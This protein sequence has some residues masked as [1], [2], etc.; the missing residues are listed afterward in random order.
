[1][2][3]EIDAAALRAFYEKSACPGVVALIDY[4][5]SPEGANTRCIGS[6]TIDFDGILGDDARFPTDAEKA[7][8]VFFLTKSLHIGSNDG[9]VTPLEWL[10]ELS[11]V[12][13]T[14]S[15]EARSR[16][17]IVCAELAEVAI[18]PIEGDVAVCDKQG[19][20][21]ISAEGANRQEQERVRKRIN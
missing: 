9:S 1:M 12:F 17:D 8:A 6:S 15:N 13:D 4:L 2:R 10:Q 18:A 20:H 7:A 19:K 5:A 3:K 21:T 16:F 11:V 14:I